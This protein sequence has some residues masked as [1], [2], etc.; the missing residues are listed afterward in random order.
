[1]K[2]APARRTTLLATIALLAAGLAVLSPRPARAAAVSTNITVNGTGTGRIFDGVGAISG[3]GGNSRLLVDYPE[4]ERSQ[5]LDYLFKPG[6]GASLQILKVEMG[7]DT[8][9]TD[10]AEASIEHAKGVIA[11]NQ[12]YEWWLMEQAKALNPGIKLYAL[13]WGAPGWIGVNDPANPDP[14]QPYFWS[15]DMIG[16]IL[17]WLGCAAQHGLTVN[18][19]GGWNERG[20]N[21]TWYE[22]LRSALNANGYA[23]I[24]VVAADNFGWSVADSMTATPAFNNAVNIVGVHYPCGYETGFSSCPSTANAE[25]LGKPLW[26]SEN[27]SEDTNDGAAAVARALNRDYVDGRMTAYINW[28]LIGAIY[29]NLAYSTDGL[30]IADQPWS[31]NYSIGKTTWVIAQTTQ[32]AQPGWQYIDSA[33]GYLGGSNANGSYVTLK[34]ANNTDYSTIIETMDATAVQTATFTVSG[35]L[36]TGTVH[37][38]S[39]DVNSSDPADYFVHSQDIAPVNGTYTVTLQPGYIYTLTTTTGQAKGT[40]TSPPSASLALP[41][42]NNFDTPAT[43]TNPNYFSDMNGAFATAPCAGGRSGTCLQQMAPATPIR[44]TDESYDAPYTIMGDGTWSNY[45]VTADALFEQPGSIDLLGRVSQEAKNNGGLDAYH[46]RISN[47]GAWSIVK[48]DTNWTF[49]TLASGSVASLG[50]DTWHTLALTMQG[51]TLT[52]SVDGTAVGSATDSTFTN[53]QAGLGVTGYQTDQF[54]NFSATAAGAPRAANLGPITSGLAGKCVDDN[55]DSSTDGTHVQIWHCN[56]TPAQNWWWANGTLHLNGLY[57][58]CMD[59]TNQ[60]TSN[61]TAV[62]VWDC[63]GGANQQWTPQA[64]GELVSAQSGKCLDDPESSTTD[65]TQLDIWTCNDG[66]NQKWTLP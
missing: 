45:T 36:S 3:G 63:N 11:C 42:S 33:S 10:G 57:G 55:E 8:N 58:K 7:G 24:Q 44:W 6:F 50:L 48:S 21:E 54:D 13:A 31:G 66:A 41:Y 37:V 5:L 43:T 27:G 30:S 40:A 19:L 47:T 4:P 52:A 46:L 34:S 16:Y 15:Q 26:A 38:W 29:P 56:G 20:Y 28:P 32:F 9:T 39:T 12:G 62:E 18:Y 23:N 64:N 22:D 17:S 14:G 53:G 60:G 25:N 2:R 65:G 1:V 59:V 51:S 35:G 61:G 49:T